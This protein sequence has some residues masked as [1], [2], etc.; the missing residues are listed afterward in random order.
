[1][2][3]ENV[4]WS[5]LASSPINWIKPFISFA[6]PAAP[7]SFTNCNLA[8]FA[9]FVVFFMITTGPFALAEVNVTLS[10]VVDKSPVTAK[11]PLEVTAPQPT[12]PNPLTFPLV[13]N[14]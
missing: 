13:S 5:W 14:V 2:I 8:P 12:V 11:L 9:S 10:L 3:S 4:T 7:L 6:A 1:M